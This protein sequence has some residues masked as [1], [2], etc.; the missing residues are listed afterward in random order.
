MVLRLLLWIYVGCTLALTLYTLGQAV[1]LIQYMRLRRHRPLAPAV[2]DADLPAVTVQLPLYNERYVVSRL[3]NAVTALDYPRD[4]LHI[5]IL[6]DSTDNTTGVIAQ[7][8][9]YLQ[10]HG[11]HIQHLYRTQRT[12]YKAGALAHGLALTDSPFVAIFDADFVPPPDFLRRTMPFLVAQP[13]LGIVQTAWGHLNADDNW[14]TKAQRLATDAHFTIEQTARSRSGWIVP[15]NGTGGVWR[16]ASIYDAGG[17]SDD[18]LTEDCDLSYRA[19]LRGWHALFLEDVVVPGELPPQ[20]SAYRQQQ[21]RWAQGNTQCLKKTAWH[22]CVAP[23]PFSTRLMAWHHLLQYLPQV[24]MLLSLLVLVPLLR[25]NVSLTI[26]PLGMVGFI[27][28]VAYV[29]SQRTRYRHWQAHLL[30]LPLLVL[31]ATSLIGRNSVAVLKGFLVRGGVFRRTPKF[32]GEWQ[33]NAYALRGWANIMVELC[34]LGYALMGFYF[35]LK[36]QPTLC[37]YVLLYVL[38]FGGAVIWQIIEQW[39]LAHRALRSP[40][41]NTHA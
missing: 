4:K 41:L 1:L 24:W 11:W 18:T 15:F 26:A 9:A 6:D 10:Q 30:A 39:Q 22:L 17:W 13:R 21:A 2:A 35:A 5:Q 3:L 20:F 38:A 27:P 16:V 12:G 23:M 28:I 34:L 14:L 7:F 40:H 29:I 36:H 33:N 32:V 19:Q 31:V 25:A 37:F 8:V